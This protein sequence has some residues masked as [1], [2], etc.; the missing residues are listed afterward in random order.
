MKKIVIFFVL[1]SISNNLLAQ[2]LLD[3]L[4]KEAPKT[5]EYV[6]ATFKGTRI[7]NG[8]SIESRKKGVLEFIISHRFGRVSDGLEELYGIDDSNIPVSYT[9]LTL[10]TIYSV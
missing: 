1:L 3:I 5:N 10:P 6:S 7:L 9:H 2:D 8:H 4:E